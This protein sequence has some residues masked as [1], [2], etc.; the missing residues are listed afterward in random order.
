MEQVATVEGNGEPHIYCK[1]SSF[2]VSESMWEDWYQVT[3]PAPPA[4]LLGFLWTKVAWVHSMT[5]LWIIDEAFG[6]AE[7]VVVALSHSEN[8]LEHKPYS[9][10]LIFGKNIQIRIFWPV[11]PVFVIYGAFILYWL[12]SVL[13]LLD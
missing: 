9:D 13:L 8:K 3:T 7:Y 10:W 4:D 6:S 12:N 2:Q 1:F 11:Q 5:T